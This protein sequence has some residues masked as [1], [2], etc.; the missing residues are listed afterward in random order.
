MKFQE[1]F[2]ERL[3]KKNYYVCCNH[4]NMKRFFS[5]IIPFYNQ[6]EQLAKTLNLFSKQDV[7]NENYEIIVVNDGTPDYSFSEQLKHC[8]NLPRNLQLLN[9]THAGSGVAR[10]F[11]A[12]KAKGDFLIFCDADRMP[13]HSFVYSYMEAIQKFPDCRNVFVGHVKECYALNDDMDDYNIM[14]SF[15]RDNQY[16]HKIL[17]IYDNDLSH[18][19][20]RWAS[21]LAGNMCISKSLFEEV[22]G[23][24][25]QFNKWGF[26]HFDLGVRLVEKNIEFINVK[27]A[28]NFHIPHS[29]A[30]DEYFKLFD[31]STHILNQK[32][33]HYN[34]KFTCLS[35]YLKGNMSLQKFEKIFSGTTNERTIPIKEVYYYL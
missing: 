9:I 13:C 21:L 2:R 34:Q 7:E 31:E 1:P 20:I 30:K 8:T 23:F 4:I 29:K 14:T 17:N 35:E 28:V 33:P 5:V 15:S 25:P 32:Y 18:S 16:Y 6:S 24:D 19:S 12:K 27:N 26:E 3:K 10:N 22:G 11:G